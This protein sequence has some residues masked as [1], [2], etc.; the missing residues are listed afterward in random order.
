M[1]CG[2]NHSFL[3]PP[4]SAAE[5]LERQRL[6]RAQNTP[7]ALWRRANLIWQLAAGFNLSEASHISG[8]HYTNAHK[9]VRRFQAEGLAGLR[10][11]PRP[12]RPS[13]YGPAREEQVLRAATSR[14]ADLGLGFTTW[15]LKKLEAHLRGRRGLAGISRETVRRILERHGLRFG[16]GQTWCASQDPDFEVKKTPS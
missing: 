1:I 5:L 8:L 4:L 9:W 16:T 15:S 13:R 6:L 3:L 14:P 7:A 10:S 2:M 11:R 12:G